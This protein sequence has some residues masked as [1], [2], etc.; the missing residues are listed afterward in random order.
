MCYRQLRGLTRAELLAG[1]TIGVTIGVTIDAGYSLQTAGLIHINSSKSAFIT[2]FYVPLVPLFQWLF[3]RKRQ[4]P[5]AW[6]AV[7]IAFAGLV[8]LAGPAGLSC[9]AVRRAFAAPGH[10]VTG[11]RSRICS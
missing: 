8:L 9:R 4:H 6:L 1:A 2:A 10:D 5:M 3:L 7:A 11:V